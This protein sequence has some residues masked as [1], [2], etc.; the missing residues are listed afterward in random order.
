MCVLG[1][2]I[3]LPEYKTGEHFKT[4]KARDSGKKMKN[5]LTSVLRADTVVCMVLYYSGER[6]YKPAIPYLE[7]LLGKP[8]SADLEYGE[9]WAL[10]GYKG[11]HSPV[12][13]W[14]ESVR[15]KIGLGPSVIAKLVTLRKGLLIKQKL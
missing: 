14:R 6:Y 1:K 7:E 15:R 2:R 10:L 9:S 3:L 8:I 5:F 12:P 4:W 11:T 13:H